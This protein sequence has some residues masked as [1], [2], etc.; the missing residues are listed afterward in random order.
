MITYYEEEEL[1]RLKRAME[2]RV[3]RIPSRQ[4]DNQATALARRSVAPQLMELFA[5]I[6]Q[7]NH[8]PQVEI[9]DREFLTVKESAALKGLSV[10]HIEWAIK[11]KKLKAHYI[12]HVR[13]RRIKRIE[14]DGYAKKL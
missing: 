5:A 3:K 9:K 13:G 14:L 6:S 10:A 1:E 7:Q 8:R 4:S 2:S 11:N 12:P